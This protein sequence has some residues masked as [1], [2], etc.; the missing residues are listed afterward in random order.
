MPFI[1]VLINNYNYEKYILES[2]N[3]VLQQTYQN[4]EIIIVD[5]GST[6]NSV[7]VIDSINDSRVIKLIKKNGG[8][9]SA[10]NE[11]FKASK[12][13]IIAFLDSD[14]SWK[15]HK[16]ETIVKWHT[17]LEGKYALLQHGVDVLENGETYSFK[18][19][20]LSGDCFRHT[21]KTG[22][23]GLF[24]GTS[25]LVFQRKNLEKVLPMPEEFRIS[26]DAYLTRT[27]FTMGFIYSIPESLGYYRRHNNAVFG[28]NTHNHT[29]FHKNTLFP[30]LN[31]FYVKNGID[32]RFKIKDETPIEFLSYEKYLMIYLMKKKF[33]EILSQYK[34]IAIFGVNEHTRW[35]S[36]MLRGHKKEH[37]IAVIDIDPKNNSEYFGLV[38]TKASEWC[39]NDADAIVLSTISQRDDL[40][41]CCKELYGK[42]IKIID[43]YEDELKW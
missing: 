16:L 15:P 4:F 35:L 20:L 21:V 37:I 17:F 23:L 42:D 39:S 11:G 24:I 26:A 32:F 22:E 2:V 28:N 14:D 41:N 25:G 12:G 6:D 33:D 27:V 19:A 9:A 30:H 43:L 13:E 5:D 3:S 7:Q 18:P 34:K 29:T 1:S 38:P 31:K 10:F 36:D 40:L 8:Q